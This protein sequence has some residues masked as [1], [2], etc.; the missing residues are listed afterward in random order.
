VTDKPK[1]R[2]NLT[3]VLALA[4]NAGVGAL[5]LAAGLLSGSA[6]LLSEA[7]HSA[8]DCTTELLLLVALRRSERPA[9]REH[10]FGYGKA[11]YFWSLLAAV[12]IFTFGGA[13]SMFEGFRAI[14]GPAESTDML[15]VNYPVLL[16]A[17][18]L[19]GISFRQAARQV[20]KQ[21]RRRRLPLVELFRH[22]EDPTVNSV[23]LEDSTALV[24]I[25]VAAIGVGLHQLTGD[26]LWDGLAS[27]VI[28]V[29]LLG[30]AVVL[31]RSCE[32]LLIGKQ[33]DPRLL[34]A[35]E[36]SLEAQPEIDDVVDLLTML[37]GTGQVLVGARVDFVD[38]VSAGQLEDAC[39]RIDEELRAEFE[40]L[41]EI[42]IQPMSRSDARMRERVQARY[43]R[44]LASPPESGS[45]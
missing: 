16:I 11:R 30:V 9:D 38:S 18:G 2:G 32:A 31:A 10:P 28:G 21:A 36:K 23:A 33:A 6:A 8:G 45:G 12:A 20:Q 41:D 19:E 1:Q 34:A 4:A 42:F 27:V 39:A 40:E 37:T 24:G 35:I 13:F 25:A 15:W 7:A 22:P 43:G 29:L 3:V 14:T 26:A 17:F 5:K 44:A